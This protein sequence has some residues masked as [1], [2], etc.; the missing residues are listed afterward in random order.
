MKYIKVMWL[1]QY[2]DEPVVVYSE[3]DNDG[4][5]TR[6]VEIFANGSGTFASATTHTGTSGLA[7]IPVPSLEEINSDP[8]FQGVEIT[9]EEFEQIWIEVSKQVR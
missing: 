9:K 5:E 3:I 1:H 6:K 7:E 2:V 8:Q 4:W